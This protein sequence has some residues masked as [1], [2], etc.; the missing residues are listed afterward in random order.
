MNSVALCDHSVGTS[1]VLRGNAATKHF[2]MWIHRI[3][4]SYRVLRGEASGKAPVGREGAT[5]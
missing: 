1:W 3:S 4:G 5:L 2:F